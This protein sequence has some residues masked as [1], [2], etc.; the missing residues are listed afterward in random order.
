MRFL[1]HPPWADPFDNHL[2]INLEEEKIRIKEKVGAR[3]DVVGE[4]HQQLKKS[5][6]VTGLKPLNFLRLSLEVGSTPH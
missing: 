5:H 2:I 4:K 6:E 3:V 1:C